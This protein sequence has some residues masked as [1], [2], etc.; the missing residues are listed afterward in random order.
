MFY[1][2]DTVIGKELD[3]V[4]TNVKLELNKRVLMVMPDFDL[5]TDETK[6]AFLTGVM[7]KATDGIKFVQELKGT[8]NMELIRLDINTIA[9]GYVTALAEVLVFDKSRYTKLFAS[10]LNAKV[11]LEL[12]KVSMERL[13]LRGIGNVINRPVDNAASWDITFYKGYQ[14]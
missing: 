14:L 2:N 1:K 4:I 3:D 7:V 9:N 13:L 6:D 5:A 10:I 11:E 12:G 8:S